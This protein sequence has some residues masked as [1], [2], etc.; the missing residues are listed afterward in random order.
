MHN[1]ETPITNTNLHIRN[2]VH[3]VREQ[4][5]PSLLVSRNNEMMKTNGTPMQDLNLLKNHLYNTS[6]LLLVTIILTEQITNLENLMIDTVVEVYHVIVIQIAIFHHKVDIVLT[7]E[8]GT[9]MTELL[10]LHN[11][12]DQD[13]TT[14]DEIHVP[15]VHPTDL[16]ID[17][18]IDKILAIDVNYVFTLETDNFQNTLHYLDLLLNHD[19]PDLLDLDQVLKHE[20]IENNHTGE[21]NSPINFETHMYHPTEMANAL[22]PTSW[23]YSLYL[24]TPER[25]NDNDH[26]SRV[27]IS[28][29]LD[30]GASISVLN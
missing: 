8:T 11:L 6:V 4:I 10:L 5:T 1:P 9:G 16:H 7:L 19:S 30:S 15:I 24:H 2:I 26:P 23:L 27:E 17:Q 22:T 25:H 28:F 21:S 20:K 18:H 13:M 29:L 3:I 14:I 12:T